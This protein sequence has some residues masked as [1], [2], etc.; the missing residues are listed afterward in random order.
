MNPHAAA[1]KARISPSTL[2]RAL[3]RIRERKQTA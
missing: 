3:K 1:I 2:Y